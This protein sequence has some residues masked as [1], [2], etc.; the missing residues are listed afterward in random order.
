M[1]NDEEAE[2]RGVSPMSQHSRMCDVTGRRW[3]G[4][5]LFSGTALS[6]LVLSCEGLK[7]KVRVPMSL[8]QIK[9]TR[10]P[11][12]NQAAFEAHEVWF[13]GA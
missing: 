6:C 8:A 1:P 5:S 9:P 13:P 10:Y 7:T 12:L 3:T 4:C 2:R 11:R